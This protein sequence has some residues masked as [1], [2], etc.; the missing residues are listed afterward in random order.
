MTTKPGGAAMFLDY[1]L[2]EGDLDIDDFDF[3]D[4]RPNAEELLAAI[5]AFRDLTRKRVRFLEA[6]ARARR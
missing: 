3:A 5:D 4:P 1:E 6:I 2:Y